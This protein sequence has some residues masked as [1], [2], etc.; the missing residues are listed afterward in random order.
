MYAEAEPFVIHALKLLC[1]RR[2]ESG[3]DITEETLLLCVLTVIQPLNGEELSNGK[4]LDTHM[5]ACASTH[6][7]PSW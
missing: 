6:R 7:E 5:R 2:D 4:R 3:V 1:A